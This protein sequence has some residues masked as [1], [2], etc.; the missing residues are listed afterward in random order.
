MSTAVEPFAVT[1]AFWSGKR[2]F[3]TGHT[4]F[5]GSWLLHW[6]DMLGAICRGY[7]LAPE[8]EPAMFELTEAARLCDHVLGDVRDAATLRAALLAFRPDIV[9]HMA[10]QPLV[11]RSYREPAETMATNVMGTVNLLE[12]CRACDTVGAVVIVTTDKCYANREWSFGYRE[13]DPLGGKDPYSASKACAEIVTEAWRASF[14]EQDGPISRTLPTASARAGNVIGGGDYSEDRLLP[15]AVRAFAQGAPVVIRA[16]GAV[17]PWQHCLDPLGGYL[18]LARACFEAG[19]SHARAYNFGPA[20]DQ[21]LTVGELVTRFCA[22]WGEGPHW[23]HAAGEAHLK[24][25]GLLLLDAGL[26]QR[27][28]GWRHLPD[29]DA[30][31]AAT[32]NWYRAA[33]NREAPAALSALTRAQISALTG[34]TTAPAAAIV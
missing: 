6:F 31:L 15:D 9:I 8:T 22:A 24:E 4:G 1:P 26:A 27:A 7:A 28:L 5:K 2:V 23:H 30:A 18:H 12:A 33:L 34:A 29:F 13:N 10:A 17:R 14:L 16:P 20:P 25:A 19:A 32:V 11:R 21:L 3:L